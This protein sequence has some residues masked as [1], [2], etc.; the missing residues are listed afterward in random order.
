MCGRRD[1]PSGVAFVNLDAGTLIAALMVVCAVL[2]ALLALTWVQNRNAPAF[3]A[4]TLCFVLS[5]FAAGIVGAREW[6][7]GL[8]ALDIA[9][10]IRLLAFGLA[11]Q[12][13]RYL[14]QRR[15]NWPLAFGGAALWLAICTFAPLGDE[16]RPRV[17]IGTPLVAAYSFALAA[18]LW[19]GVP[20]EW[21]VSRIAVAVLVLHG[22]TFV[23]RFCLALFASEG[24][25]DVEIGLAAPLHPVNILGT[26]AVCVSLAFLL[27]SVTREAMGAQH[28]EEALRDPL[29]GVSNRRG[30]ADEVGRMLALARRNGTWTAMLLIDLDGFKGINDG[31][32]HMAGDR[33]LRAL[34]ETATRAL[35]VDAVFGRLGGDEFAVALADTRIDSAVAAAERIRAAVAA[36]K[37]DEAGRAIGV[38]VSIGVTSQRIPL[39]LDELF[40]E[41]DTALYRAKALGG[42][43]VS[44]SPDTSALRSLLSSRARDDRTSASSNNAAIPKAWKDMSR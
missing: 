5:A 29:T 23:V 35:D 33:L 37:I 39:S 30:F 11:W 31:Y 34:T 12:A 7:P 42:D 38:T 3:G 1:S 20:R 27:F 10:A 8:L 41:A 18:E 25:T 6:F 22:T 44:A 17:L 16:I 26:I 40:A 9:N 43:C 14:T 21:T 24:P 13:A 4:W 28:R 32:G 2:A 19:R 15:P 36:T